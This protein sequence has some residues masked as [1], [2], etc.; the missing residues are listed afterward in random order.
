[1]ANGVGFDIF[2]RDKT[3]QAFASVNNKVEGLNKKFDGMKRAVG[4]FGK[5]LGAGLAV[6]F[7]KGIA[8]NA[9]KIDDL[10]NR[11]GLGAEALSRYQFIADRGGVEMDS[12]VT[13]MQKLAKNSI[14][15][16]NGNGAAAA[17]LQQLGIDAATFKNLGMDAQFALVAE[18]IQG[19]NDP[20]QRVKIAMDLMGKSGADM[21]QVMKGGSA[22]FEE[23]RNRADELGVTMTDVQSQD[24]AGMLDAFDDL[25]Y[26]IKGVAQD[27][28]AFLAPAITKV[29]NAVT[30]AIRQFQV[31]DGGLTKINWALIDLG[32][33]VGIVSDE[34]HEAATIE[35]YERVYGGVKKT[36]EA[37][38]EQDELLDKINGS[39][40]RNAKNHQSMKERVRQGNKEIKD[41]A[42][43][44]SDSWSD[45]IKGIQ[46]DF[47][48]L[49][50]SAIN[51]IKQIGEA[52]VKDFL[53]K[54]FGSTGGGGSSFSLGDAGNILGQVGD[55]FGGF[56]AEGGGTS[57]RKPIVVGDGGEPE[58]FFPGTPGNIVPF[59]KMGGQRNTTVNVNISTPDAQSFQRSKSQIAA[60]MAQAVQQGNRNL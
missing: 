22:A 27:L 4:G 21:L 18:K 24:I 46:I 42:E 15:A 57:G 44:T 54:Q 45:S 39:M 9:A 26:S 36:N 48:D 2:A 6:N 37:L 20:A 34:F 3:S 40:D 59:S 33:S 13:S 41:S 31:F 10:N 28:L 49:K 32:H 11:L 19:V 47:D 12:L 60:Q 1:M 23:M 30:W 53:S 51:A 5:L 14:E 29:V 17:A 16:A 35:A 52:W 56:F 8:E 43:E 38:V 55:W 50:G 25:M 7:F 58:M